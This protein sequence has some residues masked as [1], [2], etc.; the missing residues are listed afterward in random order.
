[1]PQKIMTWLMLL[2][3]FAAPCSYAA[4]TKPK[5][6]SVFYPARLIDNARQNIDGYDW[7][8]QVRDGVVEQAE[9]W[10]GLSDQELWD[11]MFGPTIT[12][13]WMVQQCILGWQFG[14]VRHCWTSQQWHPTR[15]L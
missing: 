2:A 9:P 8:K 11:L 12:R 15:N 4:E 14:K 7:A 10:M 3:V 5:Q 6:A 1:M 13:S